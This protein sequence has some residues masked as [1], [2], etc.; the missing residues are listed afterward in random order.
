MYLQAILL[1]IYTLALS[2]CLLHLW[3]CNVAFMPSNRAAASFANFLVLLLDA[4][5][6]LPA[7]ADYRHAVMLT[8]LEHRWNPFDP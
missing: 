2:L 6:M 4:V 1:S 3:E 8:G 5:L 7:C